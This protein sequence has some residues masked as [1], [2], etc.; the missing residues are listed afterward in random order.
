VT[1]NRTTRELTEEARVAN[2]LVDLLYE[3]VTNDRCVPFVGAGAT[4]ERGNRDKG[5]FA[6]IMRQCDYGPSDNPTFPEVMEKYCQQKDGGKKHRLIRQAIEYIEPFSL[7][8]DESRRASLV[9]STLSKIPYFKTFVTTN[10]DPFLERYLDV[11]VPM[12]EDRDIA[13]WDDRKRQVLKIHGCISRPYSLVATEKDYVGC[14]TNNPVIFTKLRDLMATKTFLFLGYSM[15]DSDFRE[16]WLSITER[17]GAFSKLA[18]AVMPHVSD[19]DVK[20]WLER[21]IQV[22]KTT[23]LLVLSALE[24]RLQKA[25]L[26]PTP[27]FMEHLLRERRRIVKIHIKLSQNSDGGMSSSMYQDGV[28]HV[29]DSLMRSV[30]LGTKRNPDFEAE[31]MENERYVKESLE[32][33]DPIEIA[34]SYGR[35][36]V[37]EHFC[38]RKKGE[39][40]TYFHPQK[41]YPIAKFVRGRLWA[42]IRPP[43]SKSTPVPRRG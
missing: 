24:L 34:Y 18:Y 37:M 27:E 43:K 39:I 17:L 9:S 8:G 30:A 4:T 28:L 14:M 26:I 25:A 2:A 41:L 6:S 16:V 32:A 33:D 22:F 11:L 23:D 38:D 40:P 29:L 21:G 19:E 13:F 15:R 42:P 7:P 5:F 31:R 3:E 12:V 36:T 35:Y 20:W 1:R 10:W